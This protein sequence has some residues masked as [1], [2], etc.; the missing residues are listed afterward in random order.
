MRLE[1]D[2]HLTTLRRELDGIRKQ[3]PTYLLNPIG[4]DDDRVDGCE[5]ALDRDRSCRRRG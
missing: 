2:L 1:P 5:V 3:V 4:I